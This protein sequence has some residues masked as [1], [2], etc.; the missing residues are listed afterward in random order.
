MTDE[1]VLK[2]YFQNQPMEFLLDGSSVRY[3]LLKMAFECRKEK[4]VE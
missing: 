4:R 1:E 3:E 2:K